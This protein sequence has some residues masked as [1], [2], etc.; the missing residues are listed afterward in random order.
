MAMKF[1]RREFEIFNVSFLDII[2]CGFGAIVLLVLISKTSDTAIVSDENSVSELLENI[3]VAEQRLAEKR[4]ELTNIKKTLESQNSFLTTLTGIEDSKSTNLQ[5][6]EILGDKL[7]DDVDGLSLVVNSIST[8]SIS[9]NTAKRRDVEVG[10]IPVDSDYVIFII[11]TSGSM[12]AIWAR[13]LKVLSNILDIHPT[14]KG[15]QVLNDNGVYLIS[16]Y[17]GR[18]I[19]DTSKQRKNVLGILSGWNSFSN[20]SPVEGLEVAL[21]TYSKAGASVSIYVFGDDYTGS[22]YDTVIN[23]LE[24]LNKNKINGKSII[25]VHAVGF[26]SNYTTSRFSILMREVTKRNGG[27]FLGLPK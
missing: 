3:S 11:D 19:K 18:W 27:T 2:S 26:S 22:S 20:S 21:R 13:V 12:K 16:G 25:K 6:A 10:G 17:A 14:V 5:S 1:S 15:F 23:T 4:G 24:N 7:K 8:A 9:Q